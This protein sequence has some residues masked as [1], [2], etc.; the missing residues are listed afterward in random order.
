ML[1]S[2]IGT[3]LAGENS[4]LREG[5]SRILQPPRFRVVASGPSTDVADAIV[6]ARYKSSL[7]VIESGE[8]PTTAIDHIAVFKQRNPIGRV[9]VLGHRWRSS[10]ILAAFQIGANVYFAKLTPSEEFIKAIE[11][12]ILGQTLLPAELLPLICDAI[13]DYY[14][15]EKIKI[16]DSPTNRLIRSNKR[17]ELLSDRE[18]Q[19]L[20]SITKGSSNKLIAREYDIMEATVKVHV[21]TILRKIGVSN[22]TQAA[23][24]AITK[25]LPLCAPDARAVS[26]L[27]LTADGGGNNAKLSSSPHQC[28][29]ERPNIS[30]S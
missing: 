16:V 20:L 4:L 23:M 27:M 26:R 3:I 2:A 19:I 9:A 18:T 1:R 12:V 10:D 14:H 30:Q 28:F 13:T 5:L 8:R 6:P 21:K 15:N 24:W 7:L 11:L 22:R 25:G 29:P 17:S